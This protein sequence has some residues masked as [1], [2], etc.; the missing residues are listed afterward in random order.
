M[1]RARAPPGARARPA[2][3]ASEKEHGRAER[4]EQQAADGGGRGLAQRVERPAQLHDEL[5]LRR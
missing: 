2:A 4:A 1:P 5:H 3:K